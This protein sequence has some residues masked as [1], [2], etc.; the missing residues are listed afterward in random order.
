MQQ[1]FVNKELYE[2]YEK[3]N[4]K[5]EPC[6]SKDKYTDVIFASYRWDSKGDIHDIGKNIVKVLLKIGF[7]EKQI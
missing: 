5:E 4:I 1:Y 7:E 6:F 3:G 2:V